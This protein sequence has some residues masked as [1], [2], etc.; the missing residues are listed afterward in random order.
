[1]CEVGLPSSLMPDWLTVCLD[2]WL[3]NNVLGLISSNSMPQNE[4][5]FWRP[6]LMVRPKE[7]LRKGWVEEMK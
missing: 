3:A 1:M 7:G 4:N 6:R 5:V 2:A